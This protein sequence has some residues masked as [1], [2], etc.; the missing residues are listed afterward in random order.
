[1]AGITAQVSIYPLRQQHL[2]AAID[3]AL[4]IF[5]SSGLEVYPGTMSTLLVGEADSVFGALK[6]AFQ[7]CAEKGELVMT[8]TLSNAC[9]V[10]E[11][12]KP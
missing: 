12:V 9:P 5:W 3:E 1:M 2:S 4:G 10:P 6:Q 8:V 11:N 7:R